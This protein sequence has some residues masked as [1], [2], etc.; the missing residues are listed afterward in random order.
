[1]AL[2]HNCLYPPQSK[3][4]VWLIWMCQNLN[5]DLSESVNVIQNSIETRSNPKSHLHMQNDCWDVFEENFLSKSP[6]QPFFQQFKCIQYPNYFDGI[7]CWIVLI[8][9]NKSL[10]K[11]QRKLAMDRNMSLNW[12]KI[13]YVTCAKQRKKWWQW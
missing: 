10:D 12:N 8:E 5:T 1:M 7:V 4:T 9:I 3:N 13:I 2:L 6:K 11:C